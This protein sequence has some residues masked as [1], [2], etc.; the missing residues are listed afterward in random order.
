MGGGDLGDT[1]RGG[2]TAGGGTR[3]GGDRVGDNNGG[4]I[5]GA[6]NF[7]SEDE[8]DEG[9][10]QSVNDFLDIQPTV[11]RTSR[12]R[13]QNNNRRFHP[14]NFTATSPPL[15]S[16]STVGACD[17]D[18]DYNSLGWPIA[19]EVVYQMITDDHGGR[20]YSVKLSHLITE[21][22]GSLKTKRSQFLQH[23]ATA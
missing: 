3:G 5:G 4:S 7:C 8:E 12:W 1:G 20:G 23:N 13:R 16:A 18:D 19:E 2:D 10:N 9:L 22:G 15:S 6:E 21:V 17:D 11:Q 14:D